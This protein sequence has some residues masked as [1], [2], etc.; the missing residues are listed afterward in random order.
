MRPFMG[1]L[2]AVVVFAQPLAAQAPTPDARFGPGLVHFRL[3]PPARSAE[4]TVGRLVYAWQSDW[5]SAV[6]IRF[7]A[8]SPRGDS[9]TYRIPQ[10]DSLEVAVDSAGRRLRAL[11]AAASPAVWVPYP[12]AALK[13]ADVSCPEP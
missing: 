4:W 8:A 11:E 13:R 2:A 3:A 1:P 7:V 6:C 10:I 5:G 12:L 9:V